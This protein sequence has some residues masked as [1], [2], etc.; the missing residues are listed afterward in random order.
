M[1]ARKRARRRSNVEGYGVMI[2]YA[3]DIQALVLAVAGVQ[4]KRQPRYSQVMAQA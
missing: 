1:P 4:S 2:G 3:G